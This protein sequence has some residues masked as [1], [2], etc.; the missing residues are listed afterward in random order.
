[1]Y[2]EFSFYVKWSVCGGDSKKRKME[3]RKNCH[4]RFAILKLNVFEYDAE[5][6]REEN[7]NYGSVWTVTCDMRVLMIALRRKRMHSK[8]R[9]MISW[10]HVHRMHIVEQALNKNPGS[11]MWM[12][13]W[14]C[15][16]ARS[17]SHAVY[18]VFEV[19]AGN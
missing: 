2:G 3:K 1:M 11:D 12:T 7:G 14:S 15:V 17:A 9:K 6:V 19:L 4:L 18:P 8:K 16:V 13:S 10:R 5:S